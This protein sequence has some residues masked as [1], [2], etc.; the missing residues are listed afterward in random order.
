MTHPTGML[1]SDDRVAMLDAV[2][3]FARTEL[4]ACVARPEHAMSR[5]QMQRML[6]QLKDLGLLNSQPEPA[7]GL[8][9]DPA[10]ASLRGFGVEALTLLAQTSPAVAHQMHGMALGA[11]LDRLHG[12]PGEHSVVA[13]DGRLGIGRQAASRS[14]AGAALS[15]E[16][17]AWL[18]DCWAEPVR[19]AERL[20]IAASDWQAIWWPQWS[21]ATGWRWC[22]GNRSG[23]RVSAQPQQH[24]LDELSL[25]RAGL[26]EPGSATCMSDVDAARFIE[27]CALHGLGLLAM[28]L[29]T[30]QR[31]VARARAFA[32]LR[33][34]GG[35]LIAQHAAVQQLLAEAEHAAWAAQAALAT[36]QALPPG[37]PALHAVWRARARLH[38]QL[39]DACSHALQVFGG[40]GYMRDTGAEKDLR[41]VNT[42]RQL[43]GSPNELTLCCAALDELL[44]LQGSEVTA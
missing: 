42:L 21:A 16:E 17:S 40:I 41:D 9:D 27:I 22:R 35:K 12:L 8:W 44:S 32:Q 34:Q 5:E 14:L 7:C 30:T 43:G 3:R 10:D 19:G 26:I 20:L 38:P 11:R 13:M 23:L 29:G 37:L 28:A 15:P 39:T 4:A 31:A 25:Q 18:G 33:R 36:L 6:A 1:G 24:G 2:R